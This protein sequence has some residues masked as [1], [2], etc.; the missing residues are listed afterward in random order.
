MSQNCEREEKEEEE[1]EEKEE[2]KE[3]EEEEEEAN[4]VYASICIIYLACSFV[5]SSFQ[6]KQVSMP[7]LLT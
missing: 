4:K 7:I 1:E 6:N 2:E 3:E 5:I